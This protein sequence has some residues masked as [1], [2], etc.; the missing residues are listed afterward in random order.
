MVK[1]LECCVEIRGRLYKFDLIKG[2]YINYIPN[3]RIARGSLLLCADQMG[4]TRGVAVLGQLFQQLLDG[5]FQ[6]EFLGLVHDL[7]VC[8]HSVLLYLCLTGLLGG[9]VDAYTLVALGGAARG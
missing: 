2:I 3:Q 7:H 9:V 5:V 8:Y 4:K 6:F 1:F